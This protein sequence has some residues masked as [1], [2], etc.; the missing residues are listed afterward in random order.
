MQHPIFMV[1][2]EGG[3]SGTDQSGPT[4]TVAQFVSH[5]SVARQLGARVARVTRQ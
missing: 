5:A 1:A 3:Q 4:I 2:A